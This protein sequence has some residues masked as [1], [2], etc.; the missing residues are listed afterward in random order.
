MNY[1]SLKLNLEEEYNADNCVSSAGDVF[2]NR[3]RHCQAKGAVRHE[4][5]LPRGKVRTS[6][7]PRR[8]MVRNA[9]IVGLTH[10]LNKA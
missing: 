5:R 4:L 7:R 9:E 1:I 8:K 10:T 6:Q 2:P 3:Q